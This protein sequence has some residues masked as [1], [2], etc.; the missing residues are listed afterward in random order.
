MIPTPAHPTLRILTGKS[1][2]N[3]IEAEE[4]HDSRTMV[5]VL[6]AI[7]QLS[8]LRARYGEHK[9]DD[10][11]WELLLELL[12]AER[13]EPRRADTR[14]RHLRRRRNRAPLPARPA[15]ASGR[16]SRG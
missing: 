12:R 1:G 4:A 8:R 9:L 3:M 15:A 16:E 14:R 7:E 13:G 5:S 6:D 2:H 10:V 11:A